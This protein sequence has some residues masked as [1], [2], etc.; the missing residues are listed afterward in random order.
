MI[1]VIV[2]I[3]EIA[4][5]RCFWLYIVWRIL[6]AF[7]SVSQFYAHVNM[8]FW[9]WYYYDDDSIMIYCFPHGTLMNVL[10]SGVRFYWYVVKYILEHTGDVKSGSYL[11]SR[12]MSVVNIVLFMVC[13]FVVFWWHLSV[14]IPNNR[15]LWWICE[16][17]TVKRVRT[18]VSPVYA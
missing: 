8:Y 13:G 15:H 18:L 16:F 6:F 1:D 10:N 17:A 7:T 5:K 3:I 12:F 2:H 14:I 4:L 9:H 11:H